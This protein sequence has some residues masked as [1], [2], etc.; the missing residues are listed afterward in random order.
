V[1][2]A[3]G[4]LA[5]LKRL[6]AMVLCIAC[7]IAAAAA[8]R[9]WAPGGFRTFWLGGG[10]GYGR[11]IAVLL[12]VGLYAATYGIS[13]QELKGNSAVVLAAVTVGVAAKALLT[14]A[15]MFLFYRSSASWLLGIAVA[16]IDPLSVAATLRRSSMSRQAKAILS[17]W[18]SF[19]DPV[20]VLFTAY[21]AAPLLNGAAGRP[22]S[23]AAPLAPSES[24]AAYLLSLA[25]NG[26]LVAV[27]LGAWLILRRRQRSRA[28]RR[29]M[30]NAW[31][32]LSVAA[33]S[34]LIAAAAW[35]GLFLGI[36][37]VGLFFRPR[38][39][40]LLDRAVEIAFFAAA[41]LLGTFL[42]GGVDLASGLALGVGAYFAQVVVG[43]VLT[44]GLP[45]RDR[46]DVAFGQQNGLTA[47]IL[48]LALRPYY[49]DSVRI[50]AV[51]VL[52]VNLMNIAF[53]LLFARRRRSA[54][55]REAEL[56]AVGESEIPGQLVTTSFGVR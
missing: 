31:T 41:F 35:V 26:L 5:A 28:P 10:T 40:A 47:I 2:D 46:V 39:S 52:T 15:F 43:A 51:A 37:A 9:A 23:G 14:G 11:A 50:I 42:L 54:T 22:D 24:P 30:P 6:S 48:A 12:A 16:Q 56:V 20:T 36:A 8:F 1:N 18:A 49:P 4:S 45:R 7:G 53:G 27:A 29:S 34:A 55:W 21:L 19:D 32:A 38:I 13:R 44:K 3:D 25:G 33:L 17:A